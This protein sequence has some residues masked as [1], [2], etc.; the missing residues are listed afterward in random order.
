MEKISKIYCFIV[1]LATVGFSILSSIMYIYT[2][3]YYAVEYGFW[4]A[5]LSFIT[6]VFSS[7]FLFF[8][9]IIK[10]GFMNNFTLLVTLLLICLIIVSSIN[11]WKDI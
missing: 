1:G 8:E 9:L 3:Y 5:F 11:F 2:I 10:E 6:P 7:I 4:Q